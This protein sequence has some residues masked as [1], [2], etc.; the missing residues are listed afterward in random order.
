M[1]FEDVKDI[2]DIKDVK[3]IEDVEDINLIQGGPPEMT[4]PGGWGGGQKHLRYQLGLHINNFKSDYSGIKS[5]CGVMWS[6]H[7]EAPSRRGKKITKILEFGYCN[8]C[9]PFENSENF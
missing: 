1:E 4:I 3:Y 5:K 6:P 8:F 9:S 7:N 2:K